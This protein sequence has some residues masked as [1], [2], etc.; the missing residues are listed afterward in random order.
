MKRLFEQ[1]GLQ[2]LERGWLSS[3]NVVFERRGRSPASVVD[4]GYDSHSEQTSVLVGQ[5]LGGVPLERVVNTHLHSDHCGGNA[6]LQAATGC[7]VWVPE[8][9]LEA[10][11]AW[12][13]SR[14]TFE[15]TGQTCQRFTSNAPL[16]VG[17]TVVLGGNPWQIL[18]APGH[19]SEAVMFFQRDSRV[20]ISGDA[21]WEDRLAIIF[22]AIDNVD[23]FAA[24]RSV[25]DFIETIDPAVVIPGH[26][27]PFGDVKAAVS[28]S[29]KRLDRFGAAPDTH[30]HYAA[31]AL[32]MFHMLEV[33]RQGFNDLVNWV[34][35]TPIF[36]RLVGQTRGAPSDLRTA[37]TSVIERLVFDGVLRLEA[38]E[39]LLVDKAGA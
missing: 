27:K 30:A 22:S 25:L 28:A 4:T 36:E 14:L 7:E 1:L 34:R 24:A 2:V 15:Q 17:D 26:G 32:T 6:A 35:G 9:S 13:E 37:A 21:L 23:G 10:V 19:D 38:G 29:R 31:R 5:C 12:D 16:S 3:N 18:P 33:R 8:V 39:I 11:Q 20:L